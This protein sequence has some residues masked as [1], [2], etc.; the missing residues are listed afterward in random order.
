MPT[1]EFHSLLPL[2]ESSLGSINANTLTS[3]GRVSSEALVCAFS[4]I[5]Q[6]PLNLSL[7]MTLGK[8]SLVILP[9][10]ARCNT[11]FILYLATEYPFW[12][13][14]KQPHILIYPTDRVG[15]GG[16]YRI[17]PNF[18]CVAKGTMSTFLLHKIHELTKI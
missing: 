10:R 6:D 7:A 11:C 16:I 3:A 1:S 8:P 5:K 4:I 9:S 13:N 17:R 12:W 2:D 14:I 15:R 18:S